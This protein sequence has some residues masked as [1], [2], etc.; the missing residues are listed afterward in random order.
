M[1]SSILP[2]DANSVMIGYA[3]GIIVAALIVLSTYDFKIK[4]GR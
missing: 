4:K 2:L 3:A 1:L